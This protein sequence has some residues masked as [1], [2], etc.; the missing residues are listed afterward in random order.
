MLNVNIDVFYDVIFLLAQ[1]FIVSYDG[2][3]KEV[4]LQKNIEHFLWLWFCDMTVSS[5]SNAPSLWPLTQKVSCMN[6]RYLY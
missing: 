5:K 6:F 1:V 3:Y 2:A 4:R